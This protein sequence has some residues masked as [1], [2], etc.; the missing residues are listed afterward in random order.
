MTRRQA[1]RP[2]APRLPGTGIRLR[3]SRSPRSCWWCGPAAPGRTRTTRVAAAAHGALGGPSRAAGRLDRGPG[4]PRRDPEGPPQTAALLLAFAAPV[5]VGERGTRPTT[6][7][8]RARASC[9][10]PRRRPRTGGR[11]PSTTSPVRP[12]RLRAG[13]S[14]ALLSQC[15]EDRRRSWPRRADAS[16]RARS[17]KDASGHH[18]GPPF[19]A[20]AARRPEP[21]R[22]QL[23]SDPQIRKRIESV[24]SLKAAKAQLDRAAGD[25]AR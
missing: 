20:E 25:T 21:P 6:R 14:Q 15:T 7:G 19:V 12:P 17:K 10:A 2:N 3:R 9:S 4:Q 18:E 13:T 1:E 8:S 22:P 23:I 24:E 5:P 16:W 11:K